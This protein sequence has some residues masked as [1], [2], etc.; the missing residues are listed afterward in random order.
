MIPSE[1]LHA[2]ARSPTPKPIASA[3]TKATSRAIATLA[4]AARDRATRQPE[5]RV[6]AAPHESTPNPL[7]AINAGMAAFFGA[8]A[9]IMMFD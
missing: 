7:W 5:A 1:T 2:P 4:N 8:I 9:L 3:S 6:D